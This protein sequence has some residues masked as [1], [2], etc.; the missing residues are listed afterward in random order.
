MQSWGRYCEAVALVFVARAAAG[1]SARR[2]HSF[3]F[4]LL[5]AAVLQYFRSWLLQAEERASLPTKRFIFMAST[6]TL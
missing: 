3:S 1:S 6:M 2:L 5:S 4:W